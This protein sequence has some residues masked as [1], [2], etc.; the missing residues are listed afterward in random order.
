MTKKKKKEK[1]IKLQIEHNCLN[2]TKNI[3][4]KSTI[5]SILKF[6][7]LTLSSRIWNK[8]GCCLLPIPFNTVL[9]ILEI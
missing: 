2:L 6:R 4:R 9:E 3:Y 7:N 5:N 1:L 8:Q